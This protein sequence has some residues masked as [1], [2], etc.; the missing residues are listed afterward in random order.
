MSRRVRTI[1]EMMRT[2]SNLQAVRAQS[3]QTARFN[4]MANRLVETITIFDTDDS[5]SS[6]LPDLQMDGPMSTPPSSL[7]ETAY[8]ASLPVFRTSSPIPVQSLEPITESPVQSPVP[9]SYVDLGPRV[10]LPNIVD[11]RLFRDRHTR[12][13]TPNT[14]RL[15]TVALPRIRFADLRE[16][17]NALPSSAPI[18]P[19][20]AEVSEILSSDLSIYDSESST[21]LS[22][23][24]V[25]DSE[26]S[27]ILSTS[28]LSEEMSFDSYYR[29]VTNQSP[30]ARRHVANSP[31]YAEI[32]GGE[33]FDLDGT[34][35]YDDA[36]IIDDC[37]DVLEIERY[38][39]YQKGLVDNVSEAALK[40]LECVVCMCSLYKPSV[41]LCGHSFCEKC[42]KNLYAMSERTLVP[43]T[44]PTC[45]TDWPL[46]RKPTKNIML[47]N[48]LDKLAKI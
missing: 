42:V 34:V 20:D 9:S 6:S 40:E 35:E 28:R 30:Y 12:D 19:E 43:V 11:F 38:D 5:N 47:A 10:N 3:R 37:D 15:S 32:S 33:L 39:T 36:S 44:C 41:G 31:T 8:F 24:S 16:V 1:T 18:T 14:T 48:L 25:Y 23:N 7:N 13:F 46:S 27:T 4:P 17:R 21:I 26:S 22:S 29:H 2:S 45:R